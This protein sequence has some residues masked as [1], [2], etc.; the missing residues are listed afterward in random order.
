MKRMGHL[1]ILLRRLISVIGTILNEPSNEKQKGFRLLVSVLWQCY[2]RMVPFPII[3]PLDNGLSYIADP[4]AGNSAGV[5]YT[6]IYESQYILFVRRYLEEGGII[7]DVGAHTG[8]YTLL[9][10][11]GFSR[12]VLFEP[13]PETFLL[14]RK[15]L[16]INS[17]DSAT[18]I[19]AAVSDKSGR[20]QLRVDGRYS[21]TTRLLA[22]DES[23]EENQILSVALL[24]LDE[25][26]VNLGIQRIA[27]L[28]IDTEGHEI[29]VLRGARKTLEGSPAGLVLYE[30][31]SFDC[32][33]AFFEEIGWKV[34]GIDRDSIPIFDRTTLRTAYNLFA[35]GPRN[36]LFPTILQ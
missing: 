5:I 8:L 31:S 7:L 18:A 13:D 34:F 3:V 11:P 23:H 16:S 29:H 36:S 1:E 27:F 9:L 4:A 32:A 28:K 26:V 15:N 33:C 17:L 19:L 20:G 22:L 12:A 25:V 30:N 10:A 24:T 21:G 2:K 6:R 14:L 35:C